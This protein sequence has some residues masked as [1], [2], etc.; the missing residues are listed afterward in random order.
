MKNLLGAA[1]ILISS[2]IF[3]KIA[4]NIDEEIRSKSWEISLARSKEELP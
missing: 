3:E 2:K 4:Q 1:K